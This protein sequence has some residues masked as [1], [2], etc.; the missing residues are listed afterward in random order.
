MQRRYLHVCLE[1]KAPEGQT[2]PQITSLN[3]FTHE[4][5]DKMNVKILCHGEPSQGQVSWGHQKQMAEPRFF[6]FSTKEGE[7]GLVCSEGPA[8]PKEEVRG[9]PGVM[10]QAAKCLLT[11]KWT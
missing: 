6:P 7:W 8:L 4:A 2:F 10:A 9:E 1:F 3:S 5:Q 11:C